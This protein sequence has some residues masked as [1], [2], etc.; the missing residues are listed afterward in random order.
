M[1]AFDILAA[2]EDSLGLAVSGGSD[3]TA[4]LILAADWGRERGKRIEVATVDHGLRPE[5]AEEAASDL[6]MTIL[7]RPPTAAELE[8]AQ[9]Q[10]AGAGGTD[11]GLRELAWA[12]LLST[13][14]SL[15]H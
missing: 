6:F 7:S 14:F 15:N 8:L 1:H 12:L 4:L 5:A 11:A 9:Q 13:E 2:N 3:S 10:L